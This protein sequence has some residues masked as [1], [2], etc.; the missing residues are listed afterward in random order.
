MT[1]LKQ[2]KINVKKKVLHCFV[3]L[4]QDLQEKS[5]LCL[6]ILASNFLVQI[7]VDVI[8]CIH[9]PYRVSTTPPIL[10]SNNHSVLLELQ[11]SS[12]III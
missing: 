11:D 10:S 5:L 7:S 2:P 6:L 4:Q 9:N 3:G 8:S 1:G 12:C